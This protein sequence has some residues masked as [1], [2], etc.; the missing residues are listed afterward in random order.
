MD[1]GGDLTYA[2][3]AVE[4]P[5]F[6]VDSFILVRVS[7]C[8]M[9]MIYVVSRIRVESSEDFNNYVCRTVYQDFVE[10]TK[11]LYVQCF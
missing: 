9:S 3:F 11:C 7:V 8:R 10:S 4:G 2:A 6:V 5:R 1:M